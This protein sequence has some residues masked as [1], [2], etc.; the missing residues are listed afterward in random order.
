MKT[1]IELL[2]I[3]FLVFSATGYSKGTPLKSIDSSIK[4]DFLKVPP[5]VQKLKSIDLIKPA[6]IPLDGNIDFREFFSLLTIL[7]L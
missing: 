5:K 3:T 4:K 6:S 1:N 2:L 7:G